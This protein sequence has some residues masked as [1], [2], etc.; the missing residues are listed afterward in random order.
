MG[1][2]ELD[3]ILTIAHRGASAYEPE[4]SLRSVRRTL[5][6][7]ANAIEV[8]IRRSKDGHIVVIHDETVD[9]TTDGR[10]YVRN[11]TLRELRGLDAGR[12]ERIP[13]LRAVVDLVGGRARLIVEVR[14]SGVDEAEGMRRFIGMSVDGIVTNRPDVLL[15]ILAPLKS[16]T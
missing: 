9:R 11:M 8:D 13:T 3:R 7:G 4:N 15:K 10:G 1:G 5:E 2:N 16:Q 6:F 14:V 12:E